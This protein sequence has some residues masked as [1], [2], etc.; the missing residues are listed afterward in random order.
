[1]RTIKVERRVPFG[2]RGDWGKVYKR[3]T[4]SEDLKIDDRKIRFESNYYVAIDD[5]IQIKQVGDIT[6]AN[7]QTLNC[8]E[9]RTYYMTIETTDSYWN[10]DLKEYSCCVSPEDILFAF[11]RF[12]MVSDVKEVSK[13]RPQKLSFYYCELKSMKGPQNV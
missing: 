3:Y 11:N 13:F 5:E 10:D 1:M 6:S 8:L 9:M 12:W 4:N 7:E 2:F